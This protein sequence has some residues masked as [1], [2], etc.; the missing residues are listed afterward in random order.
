MKKE[1]LFYLDFIR[2]IA[3]II[4]LLTHYNARFT[5]WY[6]LP[7]MPEKAILGLYPFNL[8]IGDLGVSLFFIISGAALMYVYQKKCSIKEFYTKRFLSIYPMFW[9]AYFV[10]FLY[11]FCQLKH[12]VNPDVP[13]INI[14]LTIFGMDGYL[15]GVF[16]NFYILGE[17]FLGCIILLYLIFPLLRKLLTT[18]PKTFC[19]GI[20][21][22]YIPFTFYNIVPMFPSSKILFV[23]FPEFVFG[24]LFV[25]YIKRSRIW[26]A[27]AGILILILNTIFK[28]ELPVSFQ[29]TY[30]GISVFLILV[31]ISYLADTAI[32]QSICKSISKYSYAIFLTHHIILSLIHILWR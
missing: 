27:A 17:W 6:M 3:V 29:T 4:I 20:V 23:R 28:P 2:A 13:K 16:P 15:S 31:L 30:I 12:I 32:L 5:E 21:L 19:I 24:M 8:Y 7:A 10:A 22:L 14:L 9:I 25:L 26:M 1:R 11:L 18:Y